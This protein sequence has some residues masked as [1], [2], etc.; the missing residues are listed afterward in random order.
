MFGIFATIDTM[1]ADAKRKNNRQVTYL[2]D[3]LNQA[4]QDMTEKV[5]VN[6]AEVL[7]QGLIRVI[8]EFRETRSLVFKTLK[9]EPAG[10]A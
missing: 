9:E 2:D 10:K 3:S 1:S 6:P 4:F 7:R 5:G 8:N